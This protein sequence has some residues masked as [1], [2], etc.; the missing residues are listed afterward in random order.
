MAQLKVTAIFWL[1]LLGAN[2]ADAFQCY[3]GNS[4]ETLE[5][6]VHLSD[7]VLAGRIV[8]VSEGEFGTHSAVVSYYYSYK[9]DGLMHKKFFWHITVH[10]IIF[11]PQVGQLGIFFLF[12]DPSMKMSLF[13]M[14]PVNMVE[15]YQEVI[16]SINE[17]GSSEPLKLIMIMLHS[18]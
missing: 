4:N 11:Y 7:V 15:N 18:T 1:I 8:S 9:H 2:A 12:R 14:T 16:D 6:T 3:A 10:N 5:N 13:C 17:I